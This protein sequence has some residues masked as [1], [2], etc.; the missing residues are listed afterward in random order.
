MTELVSY[1]PPW[2]DWLTLVRL[3]ALALMVLAWAGVGFLASP[4]LAERFHEASKGYVDW[5][6]VTFDKMF[7]TV[8]PQTCSSAIIISTLAFFLLGLGLTAGLPD[9]TGFQVARFVF[10][11]L[12]AVGPGLPTG[13]RFPRF[14]TEQ[15]WQRRINQFGD[16][17][18]DALNYMSNGLKSGLSLV[19]CMDMVR[20]ELPAPVNQEFGL[21]MSEQRLGV[22]LEDALVRMEERLGTEDLQIVVTSI[23]ILRQSGGN[24]SETFDTIATTIR[25]RRKVQGRIRT[26]TAQGVSQGV[27][28]VAM[29]FV[30]GFVLWLLDPELMSRMWTTAL[31]WGMLAVMLGLQGLGAFLI[32]R[33]VTIRV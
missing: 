11:G 30:L 28:I 5:M 19:Q 27:I 21:V 2:W 7:L 8:A 9:G 12:L 25:E 24:L 23:L 1:A 10:A 22:P 13:Y 18:L 15:L 6:V 16:Q 4:W 33:I 14:V 3:G 32:K 26:L 29:P 20:A 31:G 17:L